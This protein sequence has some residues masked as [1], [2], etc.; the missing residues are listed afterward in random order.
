MLKT[1]HSPEDRNGPWAV[2][3]E[4]RLGMAQFFATEDEFREFE[5]ATDR[6][7]EYVDGMVRA[8]EDETIRHNLVIGN[9]F[10][11]LRH[12]A[13]KPGCQIYACAVRL[14][15]S[16]ERH[17]YPDV[18]V[19][20]ETTE[21]TYEVSEPCLIAEVLSPTSAEIDR[22]EKAFAYLSMPSLRDL[23]LIDLEANTIEH[24]SRPNDNTA[25]T[26]RIGNLGDTL[27]LNCPASAKISVAEVFA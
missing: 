24:T 26:L 14:R 15:L 25:W 8:R 1:E 22:G 6:P 17:Y 23:L 11:A 12:F 5:L 3:R 9:L 27:E 21:H 10:V 18:I 2:F 13:R 4:Y 19:T 20:C 7:H 16:A